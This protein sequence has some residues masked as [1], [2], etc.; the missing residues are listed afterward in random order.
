MFVKF[1][2]TINVYTKFLT[3]WHFP[4]RCNFHQPV[5]Y[6]NVYGLFFFGKFTTFCY[7]LRSVRY[8]MHTRQSM[9]TIRVCIMYISCIWHVHV[10]TFPAVPLT[11]CNYQKIT[12]IK[13]ICVKRWVTQNRLHTKCTGVVQYPICNI[14]YAVV[15]CWIPFLKKWSTS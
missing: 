10:R 14:L 4:E 5:I 7:S 15:L 12:L 11:T 8:V 13:S 1:C 9:Q 6:T 2:T 3:L